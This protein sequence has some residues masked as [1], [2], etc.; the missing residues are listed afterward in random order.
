MQAIVR[1]HCFLLFVAHSEGGH[2]LSLFSSCKTGVP[3]DNRIHLT[4][5]DHVA[6]AGYK[7]RNEPSS[8]PVLSREGAGKSLFLRYRIEQATRRMAYVALFCLALSVIAAV[9]ALMFPLR[10]PWRDK[11]P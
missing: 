3:F 10:L 6:V 5:Q 1:A 11:L 7:R 9:Y 8:R 4:R 2:E